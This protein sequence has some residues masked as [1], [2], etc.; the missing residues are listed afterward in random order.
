[1]SRAGWPELPALLAEIAEVADL[2]A[3]LAIASAK[4]GQEVFIAARLSPS[5]WLVA[6]I[7]WEKAELV[8]RHFCSGRLRLKVTIPLGH[9]GGFL[10]ERRRR[11]RLMAEAIAR[12][13][14]ANEIAAAANVTNR[15]ARRFRSQQRE[16]SIQ[17]D[18]FSYPSRLE[19]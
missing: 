9:A 4:G 18:L 5:N 11:S 17:P 19:D 10:A 6:A 7:G 8:S 14:S 16:R 12:G 3:A 2:D 15:T 13:A 1:M